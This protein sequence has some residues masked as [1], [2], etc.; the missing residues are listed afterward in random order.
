MRVAEQIDKSG[1]G[2]IR[3]GLATSP[4]IDPP[5]F[6]GVARRWFGRVSPIRYRLQ[7]SAAAAPDG[8]PAR[9]IWGLRKLR[10][11]SICAAVVRLQHSVKPDD[12]RGH[13]D[14]LVTSCLLRHRYGRCS[15]GEYRT[16][17]ALAVRSWPP[18]DHLRLPQP[19]IGLSQEI[20]IMAPATPARLPYALSSRA[21]YRP[22]DPYEAES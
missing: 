8:P 15:P 17:S 7:L 4:R 11:S 10:S 9:S 2:S 20:K 1:A 22:D 21:V 18:W 3:F 5:L 13:G 14:R 12:G 6:A 16:P 19:R